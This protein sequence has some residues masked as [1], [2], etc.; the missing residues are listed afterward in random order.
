[1]ITP[2]S[3]GA[4]GTVLTSVLTVVA[5]IILGRGR[6]RSTEL[7]ELRLEVRHRDAY[8]DEVARWRVLIRD[9][10]ADLRELLADKGLKTQDP[11]P[12]PKQPDWRQ[13]R[14]E[15]ERDPT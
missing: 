2:E 9:Y 10:I 14:P 3:I 4:I 1:M 7:D 13:R 5:G 8:D 6:V 15:P 11:P 12:F